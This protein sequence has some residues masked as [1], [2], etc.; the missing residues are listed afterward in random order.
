MEVWGLSYADI[1][2]MPL[3]RRHRLILKKVDL[4]QKR[5]EKMRQD[6]SSSRSRMRR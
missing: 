1:M 4:E 6:S 5:E 3:T 2:E